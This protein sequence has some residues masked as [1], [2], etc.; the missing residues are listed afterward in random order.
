[1][2]FNDHISG[3]HVFDEGGVNSVGIGYRLEF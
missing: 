3:G 1:V 2:V